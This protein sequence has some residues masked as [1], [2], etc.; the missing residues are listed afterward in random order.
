ML[1]SSVDF[2]L[3]LLLLLTLL[4]PSQNEKSRTSSVHT[5]PSDL[6]QPHARAKELKPGSQSFAHLPC[7]VRVGVFFCS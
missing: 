2:D 4:V 5:H 3:T 6:F 1:T 7:T